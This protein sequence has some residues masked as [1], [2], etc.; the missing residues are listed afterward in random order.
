MGA[1]AGVF[2]YVTV[3]APSFVDDSNTVDTYTEDSVVIEGEMNG[4]CLRGNSCGSFKLREDRSYSYLPSPDSTVTQGKLPSE[5][6]SAV[7]KRIGTEEF[8]IAEEPITPQNCNAYFDG[9]DYTY[10]VAL[11]NEIYTLDTCD[12]A[13]AQNTEL[14]ELFEEVWGFMENPTT[15]YPTI[16]EKGVGGYIF[17][18]FQNGGE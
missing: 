9:I 10:T 3:F 16:I 4:G 11:D 7:F 2:F 5:L 13:L 8:F 6:S 1:F 18:R 15:T 12:T 14:Q 17:E